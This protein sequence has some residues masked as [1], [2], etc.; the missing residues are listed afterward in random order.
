M[1]VCAKAA[2]NPLFQ[3]RAGESANKTKTW[4]LQWHGGRESRGEQGRGE[5]GERAGPGSGWGGA[6]ERGLLAR[7]LPKT[8]CMGK[9]C[10][11]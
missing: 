7:P 3:T 5:D 2:A 8:S 1:A 4:A 10:L 9:R 11:E 6:G